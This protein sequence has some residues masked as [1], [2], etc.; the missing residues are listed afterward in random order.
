MGGTSAGVGAGHNG[1]RKVVGI[2][3]MLKLLFVV[4]GLLLANSAMSEEL[5]DRLVATVNGQP[6]LYST[7]KTKID[8][9][10]LVKV[11]AFP[12]TEQSE[13]FEQ[14]LQ[15]SINLELILQEAKELEIEATDQEVEA[16]IKLFLESKNTSKDTLIEQLNSMGQT[17]EEYFRDFKDIYTL[18]NFQGR[19]IMRQVKVTDKDLENYYFR[20]LGTQSDVL[21]V[22]L[23]QILVSIESG[24]PASVVEAKQKLIGEVHAKL[25]GG[26][27]FV[28][29]VK[30]YTD[31][32]SSRESGG[33]MAGIRLKDLAP[34]IRDAVKDL[35]PG[36]F[37]APL[38]TPLGLHIFFLE[39]KQMSGGEQFQ[40]VKRQL[41]QRLM[42]EEA[43]SQT[44][45]WLTDRRQRSKIIT[46]P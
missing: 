42:Q 46:I 8:R 40:K 41:E 17:Y 45:K 24:A 38:R 25:T 26:M 13:Q 43:T 9:G 37:T 44:I 30:L 10:P 36:S 7:I 35:A 39:S 6:I 14:A 29:A 12:A 2:Q 34:V 20:Q 3:S 27:D 31:D 5:V 32:S 23:R 22:T 18:R 28:E 11:T 1:R 21:E 15:D 4:A 19:V 33:L 16:E